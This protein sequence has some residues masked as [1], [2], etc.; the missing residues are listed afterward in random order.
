[1]RRGFILFITALFFTGAA[2]YAQRMLTLEEAI[3]TALQ[4]NYDIQISKN[5]SMVA[6]LDY[7][8]RN[9]AFL[10]V[11]NGLA[12]TT[13][14]SNNQRQTL[15]DG[16]KREQKNIRSH[17][18]SASLELDWVLFDGL[19]MFATRDKAAEYIQLGSL[20]IK[21]QVVNSIAGVISTY[22]NIARQKQ[23]LKAVEEQITLNE[24][25]VRLSQYKLDI[26]TGAK[27]DVLQSKVDLNEQ[28]ALKLEQLTLIEQLKEQLNQAM[29]TSSGTSFEVSDSI[30]LNTGIGL[31]DIQIDIEKTNP[32]LLIAK[33]NID[34]AG[35]TLKETKADRLPVVSF[36]SA[37]NFSRTDN[38]KVIN[39]FSPLFNQSNGFNYGFTANIPIFNRFNTKRL[40][41]QA[42]LDIQYQQLVF[43]NQQSL[44]NLDVI[45]AFKNYELQKKALALEEENILLARENVDIVFQTYKLGAATLVQLREAQNS[46]EEANNRLIAARYATKLAE[47]ELFRLKGNLAR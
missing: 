9:A 29:N 1:M 8:Y 2:S 17:N 14:N 32:L 42:Q 25:R 12:G 18:T 41:R 36:N 39:P 34:I 10:P 5:D 37:Y 33:K 24:E 4:N 3:A 20:G 30:P 22:Y 23:Q 40:I 31:G 19:K 21:N 27:P 44:I 38:K 45:T 11:L 16:S 13:W 28:K 47:T 26:G 46:L 43:E 6:A 7:S 15:A 35:L